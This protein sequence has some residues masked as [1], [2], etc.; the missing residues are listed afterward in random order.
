MADSA[1]GRPRFTIGTGLRV[2]ATFDA[3]RL[4]SEGGLP[5][6]AEADQEL[7]LCARVAG[8]VPELRHGPVHHSLLVR[9]RVF[10]IAYGYAD[11]NDASTLRSCKACRAKEA[12]DH[13]HSSA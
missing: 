3:G 7:G 4:T 12:K 1:T 11:Q 6:L 10:Q 5:W 9:Q 13:Y 2:R 8:R